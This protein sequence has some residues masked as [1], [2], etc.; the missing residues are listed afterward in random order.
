MTFGPVAG[1]GLITAA[2][3][4]LAGYRVVVFVVSMMLGSFMGGGKLVIFAGAVE[5]APLGTWSIAALVV[6]GDL[7]TAL[8]IMANM[9][10]LYG[11]PALGR[12]LRAVRQAGHDVLKFHNWMRRAAWMG[13]AVFIAVPFQGTGAVLGVIIGRILGLSRWAIFTAIALGTVTGSSVLAA[14]GRLGR[15]QIT[16]LADHPVSA[17]A[18][19]GLCLLA[20]F[21][22]GKWFLGQSQL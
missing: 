22:L 16:A 7:G 20:T 6:Y 1:F 5:S 2:T 13:L 17:V 10:Y 8:I 9:Q 4:I 19:V 11:F 21:V 15:D 18:V 3:Q 14:V 12:R